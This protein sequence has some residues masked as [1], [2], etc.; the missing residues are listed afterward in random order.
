M[1]ISPTEAQQALDDIDKIM[2]RTR[3][4]LAN[5]SGPLQLVIWGLVWFVGFLGSYFL[6]GPK[7]GFLWLLLL[8]AAL[9]SSIYL[10]YRDELRVR[11]G[12]LSMRIASSWALLILFATLILWAATP[13]TAEQANLIFILIIMLG[14]GL[15]GIWTWR[16]MFWVGLVVSALAIIGYLFF[17]K[18][19]FIWM[20]VLGGG[21]LIASGIYIKKAGK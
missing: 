19:F 2:A 8:I 21:A 7:S 14:Y 17:F 20:A 16:A 13:K 4:E 1:D 6:S 18:H 12:G 11:Y 9:I 15:L 10:G 3:R 5:G